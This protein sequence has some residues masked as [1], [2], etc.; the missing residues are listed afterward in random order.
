MENKEY[1]STR[2]VN[3]TGVSVSHCYQCGKCSAGCVLAS[4]MDYPPSYIMRLLQTNRLENDR[5]ILSS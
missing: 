3:Q 1:L 4:D 2:V 5:K